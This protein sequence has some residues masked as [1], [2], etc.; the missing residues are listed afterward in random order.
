[1]KG[2][3]GDMAGAAA[4]FGA[5]LALAQ[6]KVAVNAPVVIPSV[7]NRIAPDS[8]IPGEVIGSLSGKTI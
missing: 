5:L 1:M 2:I 3:K 4:V 7:E 6:N 8:F